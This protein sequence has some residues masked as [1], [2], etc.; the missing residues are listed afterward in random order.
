[1]R[2]CPREQFPKIR[3]WFIDC[4]KYGKSY[5]AKKFKYNAI[6]VQTTSLYYE[7]K[8]VLTRFFY[9]IWTL[10]NDEISASHN[11]ENDE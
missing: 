1:M 6:M 11:F 10:N 5:P 9:T 8:L 2:C 4:E 7:N 3:N